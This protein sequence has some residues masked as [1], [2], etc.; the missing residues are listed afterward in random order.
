MYLFLI[1]VWKMFIWFFYVNTMFEKNYEKI[2]TYEDMLG[3]CL[4]YHTNKWILQSDLNLQLVGFECICTYNLHIYHLAD[5]LKIDENCFASYNCIHNLSK[6]KF[7]WSSGLVA[8]IRLISLL[9]EDMYWLDYVNDCFMQN[10]HVFMIGKVLRTF[11][12]DTD[13]SM[14]LLSI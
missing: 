7:L 9:K 3:G 5:R 8:T 13:L 12:V 1:L 4:F 11:W 6:I 10:T 2:W 14:M